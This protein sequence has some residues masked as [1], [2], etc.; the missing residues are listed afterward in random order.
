[1]FLQPIRDGVLEGQGLLGRGHSISRSDPDINQRRHKSKQCDHI[2][3]VELIRELQQRAILVRL[4]TE[5]S[6]IFLLFT[7]GIQDCIHGTILGNASLSVLL[8]LSHRL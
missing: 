3:G 5:Y 2:Y 8:T 4:S 6:V 1:M 7:C